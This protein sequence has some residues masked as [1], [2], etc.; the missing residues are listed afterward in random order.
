MPGTDRKEYER[1][2]AVALAFVLAALV[3]GVLLGRFGG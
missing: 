2:G 3:V 1:V